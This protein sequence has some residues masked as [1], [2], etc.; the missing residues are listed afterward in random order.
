M[1]DLLLLLRNLTV[2]QTGDSVQ[3]S[4]G[5]PHSFRS[6]SLSAAECM[7]LAGLLRLAADSPAARVSRPEAALSEPPGS[8]EAAM[9]GGSLGAEGP[10]VPDDVRADA[11]TVREALRY[12]PARS[13]FGEQR[14]WVAADAWEALDR[15]AARAALAGEPPPTT[16]GTE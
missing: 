12:A 1:S 15:L 7:R 9:P 4:V 2:I 14:R 10:S 3:I 16:E 5:E 6:V 8:P 11:D 13:G